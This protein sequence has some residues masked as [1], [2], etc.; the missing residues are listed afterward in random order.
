MIVR[1]ISEGQFNVPSTHLDR[2]NELDNQVVDAVAQED[3]ERY[4]EV[5]GKLLGLVREHGTRVPATEFVES[6]VVLPEP[7]LTFEEAKKLFVGDGLLS[8]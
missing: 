6:D 8:G 4:K 3:H 1:I 5:Y 2:L 7:D